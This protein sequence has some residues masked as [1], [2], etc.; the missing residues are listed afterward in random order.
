VYN[1]LKPQNLEN[2]LENTSVNPAWYIDVFSKPSK[3]IIMKNHLKTLLLTFCQSFFNLKPN[4]SDLQK[5]IDF[6]YETLKLKDLKSF[7]VSEKFGHRIAGQVA[8]WM[9]D[10]FQKYHNKYKDTLIVLPDVLPTVKKYVLPNNMNDTTIQKNTKSKPMTWAEYS[11]AKYCLLY[12]GQAVKGKV[13]IFHVEVDGEVL[14]L[15]LYWNVDEW[16]SYGYSFAHGGDWNAGIVFV[17][18]P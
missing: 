16:Y 8:Q 18:L 1:V 14:A 4:D 11:L 2:G 12:G 3:K 13:Y 6:I 5:I 17:S 9:S 7:V 10:T 15:F